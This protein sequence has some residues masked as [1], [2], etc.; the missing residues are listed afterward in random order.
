MRLRAVAFL[1]LCLFGLSLVWAMQ[2]TR[3]RNTSRKRQED[4]RV[5]L[6]HSDQL[7]YD[8]YRNGDA[9]ILVGNVHF[10]H[11]GANL[12]CDSANFFQQTNSFEAFGHVKMLQGDTLKLF[13]DYAYYNEPELFAHSRRNKHN[14]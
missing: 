5:Y 6:I 13:S 12:Y 1:L 10:R 9:Q 4:K 8:Q 2:P 14:H 7:R 11:M 3:K